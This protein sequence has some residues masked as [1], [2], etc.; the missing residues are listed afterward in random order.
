MSGASREKAYR[1]NSRPPQ[2]YCRQINH[3]SFQVIFEN[4][5]DSICVTDAEGNMLMANPAAAR[6]LAVPLEQLVSANVKDLVGRGIYDRSIALQAVAEKKTVT[7]II[8]TRAGLALM[9]TS[10]PL[11]NDS[12]GVEFVISNIRDTGSVDQL[13]KTLEQE[14]GALDRYRNEITYHRDQNIEKNQLVYRSALMEEVVTKANAVARVSAP[15]LLLGESGVGKDV[16]ARYI[17]RNSDRVREPFIV[18]NCAAIPENLIESELFGYDKGAFSG[19]SPQGKP[20]LMEMADKGTL[21]L[22]E[23]T[24]IPLPLQAKLLR[25]LETYE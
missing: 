16:V 1:E 23:I 13:L 5:Y 19:A 12:G 4:S 8:K 15:V 14:R 24:E 9:S 17:H 10:V 21:F 7:G 11:I 18:V 22:D 25:V 20:G 3:P 6:M 2:N